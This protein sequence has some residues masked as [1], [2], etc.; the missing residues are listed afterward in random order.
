[1]KSLTALALLTIF[2][3]C[4]STVGCAEPD[5]ASSD[6]ESTAESEL[7]K[8]TKPKAGMG[9]VL[10][11]KPAWLDDGFAGE[12]KVADSRSAQ[13][14]TPGTILDL[15]PGSYEVYFKPKGLVDSVNTSDGTWSVFGHL[16]RKQTGSL[17]V[18]QVWKVIPAGLR[19][20]LDRPLVWKYPVT[21][22][23]ISVPQPAV[24]KIH[25]QR[26]SRTLTHSQ[27]GPIYAAYDYDRLAISAEEIAAGAKRLDRIFPAETYSVQLGALGTKNPVALT[28]GNL[29]KLT[30][31]TLSYAID[32]DPID[33]AFPNAMAQCVTIES[34]GLKEPARALD[35]FKTAVLPENQPVKVK[36]F[37]LDVPGKV[38]GNVKRFPL[39]RLE[40]DDVEVAAA[41][42]G[43]T[44][45]QGKVRIEV[46]S[47]S[48][49]SPLV[50][51]S[52]QAATFLT[53]TG[54]DLP[55]GT[56]RV[57]STAMGANGPVTSTEEVSFP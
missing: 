33:P 39:N 7:T 15:V 31:K 54:V 42:G 24:V 26:Y 52:S 47:G 48:V 21:L 27:A 53:R 38:V 1:M 8:R 3:A 36:A 19:I 30:V 37:G 6:D 14:A 56:Y 49:W 35:A 9:G 20:E 25:D 40:L 11:E 57:T 4:A 43:T 44:N 41:G 12:I 10:V 13:R 29:T 22:A 34:D 50:C 51:G 17:A 55:D 28:E 16:W 45:V 32:A 46:K 5:E 23:T 2:A 18:A